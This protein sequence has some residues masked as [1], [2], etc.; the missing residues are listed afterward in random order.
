MAFHILI[1]DR[2]FFF[3]S[4]ACFELIYSSLWSGHPGTLLL[5]QQLF[6][7]IILSESLQEGVAISEVEFKP[8]IGVLD[9][10]GGVRLYHMKQS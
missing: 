3:F 9:L 2:W 6:K 7:E 8:Q 1:A 5:L 10:A 4:F